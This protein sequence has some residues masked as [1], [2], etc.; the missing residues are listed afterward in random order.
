MI[1]QN[2]VANYQNQNLPYIRETN[3]QICVLTNDSD[4]RFRSRFVGFLS[5]HLELA[6]VLPVICAHGG[7]GLCQGGPLVG[8]VVVQSVV[9]LAV[10]NF[11]CFVGPL[12]PGRGFVSGKCTRDHK[13]GF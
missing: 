6:R 1:Q 11:L 4:S 7:C 3:S 8:L 2:P 5:G 10:G 12:G 13:G 9:S